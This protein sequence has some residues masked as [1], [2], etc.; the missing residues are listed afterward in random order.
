MIRRDEPDPWWWRAIDA[1]VA[2]FVVVVLAY[3]LVSLILATGC[4]PAPARATRIWPAD[5]PTAAAANTTW[6]WCCAAQLDESRDRE[7]GMVCADTED[8]CNEERAALLKWGGYAHVDQV[9]ECVQV[10]VDN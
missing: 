5:A 7:G 4:A 10:T 3:T 1:V 9:G 6:F 8:T 2:L